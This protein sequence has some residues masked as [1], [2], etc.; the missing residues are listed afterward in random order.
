MGRN[1]LAIKE[2]RHGLPEVVP[3][4]SAHFLSPGIIELHLHTVLRGAAALED[5]GLCYIAV[6]NDDIVVEVNRS[7]GAGYLRLTQ[8][9][10]RSIFG[11]PH[12]KA[13]GRLQVANEE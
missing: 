2:D 3:S 4:G 11:Q 5:S 1:N 7:V 8:A 9:R 13:N 12:F 10:S 6:R